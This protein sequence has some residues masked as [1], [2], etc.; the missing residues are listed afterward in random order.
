[1][2]LTLLDEL[3][4]GFELGWAPLNTLTPKV[5][6]D[7]NSLCVDPENTVPAVVNGK[8]CVVIERQFQASNSGDGWPDVS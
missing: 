1:M 4:A 3:S 5:R 7:L 2:Y 8:P 6:A